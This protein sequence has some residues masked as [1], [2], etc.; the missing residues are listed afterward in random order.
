MKVL[1]FQADW[2]QPCKMLTNTLRDDIITDIP[3]EIVDIDN[4][5]EEVTNLLVKYGIR[6]VPTLV[7]LGDDGVELKRK[8]GMATKSELESFFNVQG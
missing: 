5:S 2:C 8:V 4:N 1:K 3:V 7:M 6:G